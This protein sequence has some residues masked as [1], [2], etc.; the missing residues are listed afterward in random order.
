MN[1]KNLIV[2]F[3]VGGIVTTLI[4]SLEESSLR[5]LSAFAAIVP[6]FTV[7]SYFFLGASQ[8]GAAVSAHAKLVLVGT[9][10]AWVPYMLTVIYLAPQAGSHKA[11]II[12]LGVFAVLAAAF[13]LTI[14]HFGWLR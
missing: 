13:I 7:I 6:I 5:L 1:L 11:V 10:V 8:G 2:Y 9:L 4:V 3:L 14:Q 12:G